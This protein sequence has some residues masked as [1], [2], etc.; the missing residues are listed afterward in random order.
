MAETAPHRTTIELFKEEMKFS[1]GHFTIFSATERERL[2]GHNFTVYVAI[3]GR[4]DD[5]GLMAEYGTFKQLLFEACRSL[6]EY[7]LL[8]GRSPHLKIREQGEHLY[9]RYDGVDIPFLRGDVK[10]LPVR[11]VTIEELARYFAEQLAEDERFS[12]DGVDGL[13]VKVASGPGQWASYEWT[14]NS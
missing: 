4:V 6:N 3:T 13:L 10:V 12:G 7:F 2:H 11:N 14:K 5:N 1:A 8:P 9:A